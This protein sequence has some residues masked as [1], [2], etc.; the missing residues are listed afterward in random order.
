MRSA[1][2]AL[3]SL[4]TLPHSCSPIRPYRCPSRAFPLQ[5]R[6]ES[7][8]QTAGAWYHRRRV[9]FLVNARSACARVYNI[10]TGSTR[11]MACQCSHLSPVITITLSTSLSFPDAARSCLN[12]ALTVVVM[13]VGSRFAGPTLIR[14]AGRSRYFPSQHTLRFS[15]LQR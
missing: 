12:R 9:C 13:A 4:S 2:C 15:P 8:A 7:R 6:Q 10:D 3:P 14:L 1:K 11:C 5:A